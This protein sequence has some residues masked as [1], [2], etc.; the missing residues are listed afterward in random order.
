[1]PM[2]SLYHKS[3]KAVPASELTVAKKPAAKS[4]DKKGKSDT[5]KEAK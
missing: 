4:V 1:M 3:K 5:K 2:R